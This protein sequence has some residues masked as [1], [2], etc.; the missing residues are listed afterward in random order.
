MGFSAQPLPDAAEGPRSC[1]QVFLAA[2]Q[3][4]IETLTWV[5]NPLCSARPG[6]G[7]VPG[8]E[9]GTWGRARP[10]VLLSRWAEGN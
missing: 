5:M 3:V 1:R 6:T 2:K 9:S 7:H 8:W 4:F 10:A